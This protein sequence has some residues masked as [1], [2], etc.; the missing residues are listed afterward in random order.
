MR[1]GRPNWNYVVCN[2][3]GNL[4]VVG[5]IFFLVGFTAIPGN[6]V[7]AIDVPQIPIYMTFRSFL[8]YFSIFVIVLMTILVEY[9]TDEH[10]DL[11]TGLGAIGKFTGRFSELFISLSF[12]F[13][14]ALYGIA[15]FF[16]SE[17]PMRIAV[18]IILVLSMIMQ[19]RAYG[20]SLQKA[21]P[22]KDSERR[23]RLG[24]IIMVI[25]GF[26]VIFQAFTGWTSCIS[27]MLGVALVAA[28]DSRMMNDRKRGR[29]WMETESVNPAPCVFS[30]GPLFY[31]SGWVL[32]ALAMSVPQVVW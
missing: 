9:A 25:F 22:N 8:A 18:D 5:W 4:F 1:H 32:L 27:A 7:A 3:G 29:L 2:G 16:P 28:G 10:D 26:V 30:Y 17:T 14:F 20:L 12:M 11:Q 21:V 15:S 24:R 6:A 13:S 31:T 23:S 19:G